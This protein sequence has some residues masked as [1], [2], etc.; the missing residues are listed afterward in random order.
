MFRFHSF[1]KSYERCI[2]SYH[3]QSPVEGHL[4]EDEPGQQIGQRSQFASGSV[5]SNSKLSKDIHNPLKQAPSGFPH[6]LLFISVLWYFLHECIFVFLCVCVFVFAYLFPQQPIETGA[7]WLSSFLALHSCQQA[8]SLD[9][10]DS[11]LR[12]MCTVSFYSS[13]PMLTKCNNKMYL[14]LLLVDFTKVL[15]MICQ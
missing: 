1:Y 4:V 8:F 13:F 7:V 3:H 2:T 10:W 6:P 12:M 11:C 15:Q 9:L 14:F 5:F